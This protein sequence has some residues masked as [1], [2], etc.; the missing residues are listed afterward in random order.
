MGEATNLIENR[1]RGLS[2]RPISWQ[3]SNY[4]GSKDDGVL[5]DSKSIFSGEETEQL[6]TWRGI[7]ER[8]LRT[9]MKLLGGE[10][11]SQRSGRWATTS[12]RPG[13]LEARG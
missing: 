2:E 4:S 13:L 10:S 1:S 9:E 11:E 3:R 6:L 8:V 7:H 5:G 12:R